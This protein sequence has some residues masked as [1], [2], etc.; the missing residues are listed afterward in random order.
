MVFALT[1]LLTYLLT[2]LTLLILAHIC[3]LP[4]IISLLSF[5]VFRKNYFLL[6]LLVFFFKILFNDFGCWQMFL[7]SNSKKSSQPVALGDWAIN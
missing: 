6:N 3:V 5:I 7:K 2:L 4:L 1:Y